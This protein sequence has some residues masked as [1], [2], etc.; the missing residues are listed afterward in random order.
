MLMITFPFINYI[1]E[2]E[3]IKYILTLNLIELIIKC[4]I[5]NGLREL[6]K[7]KKILF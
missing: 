7:N 2:L 1:S 6:N 3:I 5:K 4:F